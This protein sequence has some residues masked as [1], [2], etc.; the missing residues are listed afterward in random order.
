MDCFVDSSLRF[1]VFRFSD[2]QNG[3]TLDFFSV[4]VV[5]VVVAVSVAIAETIVV[6]IVAVV[7]VIVVAGVL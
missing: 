6:I 2:F 4:A 1:H 7:A 3:L 5:V